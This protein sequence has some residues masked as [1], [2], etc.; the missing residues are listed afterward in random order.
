MGNRGSMYLMEDRTR[1]LGGET[2]KSHQED[3]DGQ[4]PPPPQKGTLCYI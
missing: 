2:E 4:P 3:G 1:R